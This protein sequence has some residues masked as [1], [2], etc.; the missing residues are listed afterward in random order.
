MMEYQDANARLGELCRHRLSQ[1]RLILASNRG[2]V[3]YHLTSDGRLQ[4]RRGSGG[5]VTA[6][7]GL[8]KYVEV[9]WIASAMGEGDRQA[10]QRAGVGR[11]KV[12]LAGESPYL[13]FVVN[14]RNMYH[15]YYNIICNPLL[16]AYF[17]PFSQHLRYAN[18]RRPV[19]LEKH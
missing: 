19:S 5:V 11:I 17:A 8:S 7:S 4:G 10:V 2:P 1:R 15:K 12:P 6:L 9:D 14:P 13:R 3:E 18:Q 16:L